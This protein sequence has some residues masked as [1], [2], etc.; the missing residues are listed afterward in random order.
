MSRGY[1]LPR[2]GNSFSPS[3]YYKIIKGF[4]P[5]P[6]FPKKVQV[7]TKSGCNAKC[8][9]CPSGKENTSI[10]HGTMEWNLYKKIIDECV[11]HPVRR[12]SP[13]LSNE[14]LLDREIGKKIKYITLN[15]KD[16]TY[17][18]IN[19]NAS[20]L[21]E[22]MALSLFDSGL[23]KISISFHG[24][25]KESY[26]KSMRG[27]NFKK[28]LENVKR[29]VKLKREKNLKK[30]NIRITMIHTSVVDKELDE[31]RKFWHQLRLKVDVRALENRVNE[32]VLTAK[33]NLKKWERLKN[34]R[35]L[36]EQAYISYN[37]DVI[38]C[39]VDWERTTVLGNLKEQSLEEIWNSKKY[40]EIRK[41]YI[42]GDI[43][44]TICGK[45]FIQDEKDFMME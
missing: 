30:P 24:I 9:F 21:D 25:T 2:N 43:K 13:Y 45:C 23:D 22:E 5:F 12:I 19:T 31:I 40:M 28:N 29:F 3:F 35:R 42:N 18:K 14:P 41:K 17:T 39:C 34:C 4:E 38:L 44:D 20:L 37:G 11:K 10:P 16:S 36:M 8:L 1:F 26:E 15:K 32:K 33:L 7:E 27:L 6:E